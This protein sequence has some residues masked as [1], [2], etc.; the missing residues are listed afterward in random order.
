MSSF[1]QGEIR[2][3]VIQEMRALA[4]QHA[5]VP[6]LVKLLLN[7]L[8]LNERDALFPV[9]AYFRAAFHLSLREALPLREWLQA[10]DRSEV[11]SILLPAIRGMKDRW[12]TKQYEQV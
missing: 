11:D 5:D 7:R 10:K 2:P 3:E 4:E 12:Q 8:E 1:E 6:E 9:L